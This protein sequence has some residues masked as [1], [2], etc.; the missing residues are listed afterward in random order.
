[1]AK[2]N[3]EVEG[4]SMVKWKIYIRKWQTALQRE[5]SVIYQLNLESQI[6]T[7]ISHYP[8]GG[9][10]G[11]V[12]NIPPNCLNIALERDEAKCN[13]QWSLSRHVQCANK[14]ST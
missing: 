8:N 2:D 4:G 13:M 7:R 9:L 3:K 1:L 6:A 14:T 10:F 11:S 5:I 12:Q